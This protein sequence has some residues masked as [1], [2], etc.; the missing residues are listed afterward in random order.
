VFVCIGYNPNTARQCQQNGGTNCNFG[1]CV[2]RT[3]DSDDCKGSSDNTAA[4]IGGVIG[5][6][7]LLCILLLIALILLLILCRK[8]VISAVGNLN[9]F[10]ASTN[11]KNAATYVSPM[12]SGTSGLYEHS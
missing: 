11:V 8:N 5:G 2:A 1:Q 3:R 6:V 12:G 9:P 7:A 10:A 4:I